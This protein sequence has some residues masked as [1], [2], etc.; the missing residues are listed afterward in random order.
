M[1][2]VNFKGE[3]FLTIDHQLLRTLEG[4]EARIRSQFEIPGKHY[5]VEELLKH[6]GSKFFKLWD[7]QEFPPYQKETEMEYRGIYVFANEK[8]NGWVYQYVGISRGIRQRFQW[9]VTGTIINHATWAWLMVEGKDELKQEKILDPQ[10]YK[11]KVKALLKAKQAEI[12][13]PCKFTFVP[14]NSDMLMHLA[15]VY[16]ANHLSTHW[17]TFRTH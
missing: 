11:Q 1:E 15:E 4:I 13:H 7:E 14:I 8:D 6:S 16:C 12:I 5:K 2:K 10:A 9:H 17:N 3:R